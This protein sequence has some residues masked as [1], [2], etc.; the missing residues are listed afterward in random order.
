MSGTTKDRRNEIQA[1]ARQ[2]LEEQGGVMAVDALVNEVRKSTLVLMNKTL[3]D[4]EGVTYDTARRHIAKAMRRARHDVVIERGWG[5]KRDG[6]GRKAIAPLPGDTAGEGMEWMMETIDNIV[7]RPK[8]I[9][10]P[11]AKVSDFRKGQRVSVTYEAGYTEVGTIRTVSE[12]SIAVD[13]DDGD[14]NA[15][16]PEYLKLED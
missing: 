11:E 16:Y 15:Y 6:A 1:A 5:G 10:N 8:V 9:Q 2:I 7:E 13:L 3:V 14:W 12:N 4:R